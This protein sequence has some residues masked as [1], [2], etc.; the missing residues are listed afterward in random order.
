MAAVQSECCCRPD[1]DSNKMSG[2]SV[3]SPVNLKGSLT[4]SSACLLE[5]ANEDI[6]NGAQSSPDQN[7]IS[8]IDKKE[9]AQPMVTW[10]KI[11]A[12]Q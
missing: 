10:F 9:H 8:K 11:P 12:C 2:N 3:E 7:S 6:Q 5:S 4:L 1:T